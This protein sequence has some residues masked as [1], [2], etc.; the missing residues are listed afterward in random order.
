MG[1]GRSM[2]KNEKCKQNHKERK[3]ENFK[4][5]LKET[6][7]IMNCFNW[8][9]KKIMSEEKM[10]RKGLIFWRLKN[11]VDHFNLTVYFLEASN[12]RHSEERFYVET[13]CAQ[14]N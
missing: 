3:R 1:G 8:F 6:L 5:R 13:E 10:S 14:Y 7:Q 12:L 9:R 4:K 11:E 2:K